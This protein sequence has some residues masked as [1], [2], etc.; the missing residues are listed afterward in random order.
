MA[1][2]LNIHAIARQTVFSL[3]GFRLTYL[4]RVLTFAPL[5]LIADFRVI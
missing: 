1:D 5:K 4:N 3:K 2:P